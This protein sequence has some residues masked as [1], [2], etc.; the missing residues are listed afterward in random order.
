[1]SSKVAEVIVFG[2]AAGIRERPSNRSRT[3]RRETRNLNPTT[4][5]LSPAPT[6][7][8][9]FRKQSGYDVTQAELAEEKHARLAA[10]AAEEAYDRIRT[11]LQ[12]KIQ[13]G[14]SI[15]PGR[16]K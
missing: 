1:M 7:M 4:G 5:I 8:V 12:A 15:E 11:L 9:A 10:A 6:V 13:R 16:F 3:S 2:G 14:G